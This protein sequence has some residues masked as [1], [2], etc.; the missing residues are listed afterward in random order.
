V[1]EFARL[2]EEQGLR[3][4]RAEKLALEFHFI[5][6]WIESDRD[7]TGEKYPWL[8]WL[9]AWSQSDRN[10]GLAKEVGDLSVRVNRLFDPGVSAKAFEDGLK[11]LQAALAGLSRTAATRAREK[12]AGLERQPPQLV[13]DFGKPQGPA[14]H[15]ASGFL[16]GFSPDTPPDD[17]VAPLKPQS[18]RSRSYTDYGSFATYERARRLGVKHVSVVV[19]CIVHD[20]GFMPWPGEN[21]D[22]SRWEAGVEQMVKEAR[23]R[24]WKIEWDVW[25]EPNGNFPGCKGGVAATDRFKETWKRAV[26]KIRSLDPQAVI[27]GPS[28]SGFDE[29]FIK[30]LLLWARDQKVLPDMLSWHEYYERPSVGKHAQVMR[31]FMKANGIKELPLCINEYCPPQEQLYP[32]A[33]VLWFATLEH[34][35]VVSAN[36]ACWQDESC[37]NCENVVLNG[38]VT[39]PERDPRSAWWA[40]KSYAD[41][42]GTLVDVE[43]KMPWFDAV[44]GYD[45]PSKQAR[46]LV[47]QCHTDIALPFG[48]CI[49]RL[50]GLD[51]AVGVVKNNKV[52]VT[53][54]WIP[55]SETRPLLRPLATLDGDY[56]VKDNTVTV[57]VPN[58]GP[59]DAY[60]LTLNG[61][62]ARE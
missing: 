59:S 6:S 35:G 62:D 8:A 13:V 42:A 29:V 57:V 18:L 52:H 32:G 55:N 23:A 49:V 60:L 10:L 25:N 44:A 53:G 12:L 16:H 21:N 31:G 1:A 38:L 61:P 15:V 45:A 2:G 9:V 7:R 22:W 4:R 33:Q 26:M 28:T 3:Q 54:A 14:T 39:Y 20:G 48:P 50:V 19:S 43:P 36:K 27:V 41:I 17:V 5:K 58:M 24:N 47:G 51:K 37:N 56:E 30:D 46:V 11:D 34:A 40:F